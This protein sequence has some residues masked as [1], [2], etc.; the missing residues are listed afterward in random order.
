MAVVPRC[1][2]LSRN[3]YCSSASAVNS[4]LVAMY[5]FS[6]V[7]SSSSFLNEPMMLSLLP[8]P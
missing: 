5:S 8:S 3:E 2:C 4:H 6:L 1:T 7:S